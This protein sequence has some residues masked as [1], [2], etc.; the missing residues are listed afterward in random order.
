MDQL[1]K[2]EKLRE[3]ANVTYE[4]AKEALE[5]CDWELLDAM[6][7]LEKAGKAKGP[8]KES[9]STSYEEQTQYVSVKEKVD[10]QK[11]PGDGFWNKMGRLFK[12]LWQKC[13]DNSFCVKR[14]GEEILKVPVWALVLAALISWKLTLA[15][16]VAGLFLKCQYSF[17]GKDELKEANTVM[18]KASEL[19]DKIKN[20]YEKL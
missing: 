7:Y 14:N 16:L 11:N 4:E 10:E 17:N 20:E 19:A 1:E 6:V 13:I 18:E 3:R 12:K 5:A 15:V 8:A 2:V 9:Y